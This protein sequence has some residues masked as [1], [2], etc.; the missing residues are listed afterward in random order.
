MEIVI[1]TNIIIAALLKEGLTRKIIFLSPLDM[2]TVPH[3]KSEIEEQKEEL[4]NKSKLDI[5]S[6]KI[7]NKLFCIAN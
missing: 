1:D 5:E 3:A 4:L 6:F 2:C 7:K